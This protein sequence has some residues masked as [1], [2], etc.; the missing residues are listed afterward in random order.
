LDTDADNII[1]SS[2][3][4]N[5]RSNN[6]SVKVY[7]NPSPDEFTINLTSKLAG[8]TIVTVF[9][10]SGRQIQR[11]ENVSSTFKFGRDLKPGT[12]LVQVTLNNEKQAFKLVKSK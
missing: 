6:F 3:N 4:D 11:F 5:L 2:T 8:Q 7:P 12:Y 1:A 9:D 10:L